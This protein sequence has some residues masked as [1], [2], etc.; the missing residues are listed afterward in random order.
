M[1]FDLATKA[2][3]EDKKPKNK[4]KR[5]AETMLSIASKKKKQMERT[6]EKNPEKAD[7][8]EAA[9]DMKRAE[10]KASGEK[11]KDDIGLLKK[12]IKKKEQMKKKRKKRGGKKKKKKKKKKK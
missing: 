4:L 11:L 5:K 8:L 12:T 3:V 9:Q 2:T 1:G 7:R 6:R 10:W